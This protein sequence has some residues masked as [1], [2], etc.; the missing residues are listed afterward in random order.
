MNMMY[1][2]WIHV[3]SLLLLLHTS[4]QTDVE[5]KHPKDLKQI[6]FD[7]YVENLKAKISSMKDL[8][9]G[10]FR[11]I[12]YCDSEIR[13]LKDEIRNSVPN[14]IENIDHYIRCRTNYWTGDAAIYALSLIQKI[15]R[16]NKKQYPYVYLN[17]LELDACFK[18]SVEHHEKMITDHSETICNELIPYKTKDIEEIDQL[19]VWK[20]NEV[21]EVNAKFFKYRLLLQALKVIDD[22]GK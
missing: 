11:T 1:V 17:S 14:G 6:I 22:H 5:P 7:L 3:A 19:I 8:T 15:K 2:F 20:H 13:T 18:E 10:M 9:E 21:A 4:K 12:R 16:D